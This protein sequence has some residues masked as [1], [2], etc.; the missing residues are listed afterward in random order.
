MHKLPF[1]RRPY[2]VV[3]W[4]ALR[5]GVAC[6]YSQEKEKQKLR[7]HFMVPYFFLRALAAPAQ[8]PKEF[9]T[10]ELAN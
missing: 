10:G 1:R 2:P 9:S 6:F 4:C 7:S 8:T 5:I 3:N